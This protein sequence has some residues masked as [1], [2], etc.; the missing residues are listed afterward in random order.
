MTG[1]LEK[2][3]KDHPDKLTLDR[4]RKGRQR[5]LRGFSFSPDQTEGLFRLIS[6]TAQN[7][8]NGLNGGVTQA[9]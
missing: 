7:D 4:P 6:E 2:G 5:L 8:P 1:L 3:I 9:D